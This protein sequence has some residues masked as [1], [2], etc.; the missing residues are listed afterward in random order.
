MA[1]NYIGA[2]SPQPTSAN[3]GGGAWGGITGTI[4]DQT[5]LVD[6]I[7]DE[8]LPIADKTFTQP[9]A[10]TTWVLDH[11]RS[12]KPNLAYWNAT[13]E[14]EYPDEIQTGATELT[15]TFATSE[16]HTA[17][18]PGNGTSASIRNDAIK[19]L[20]ASEVNAASG[21]IDIAN[22]KTIIIDMTE[23][24]TFD[25]TFTGTHNPYLPLVLGFI[26]RA[27][28]RTANLAVAKFKST[29]FCAI[30]SPLLQATPNVENLFQ[31]TLG[32]VSAKMALH[33]YTYGI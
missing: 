1:G 32:A 2:Y 29:T 7:D 31:F 30:P 18:L 16:I 24:I 8:L 5:D 22:H 27:T 19:T 4:T 14:R 26:Q 33:N 6:Y 13:G 9:S 20:L 17:T 10:S 28:P 3:S 23:D 25:I 11:G 15:I 21:V 12:I